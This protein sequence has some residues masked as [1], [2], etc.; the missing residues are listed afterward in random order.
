MNEKGQ[1]GNEKGTEDNRKEDGNGENGGGGEDKDGGEA[2]RMRKRMRVEKVK[3]SIRR[4]T[5]I[6]KLKI[7]SVK[8]K[9][10]EMRIMLKVFDAARHARPIE[11]VAYPFI[12][13]TKTPD[14]RWGSMQRRKECDSERVGWGKSQMR[15][16]YGKQEFFNRFSL[17]AWESAEEKGDLH[18]TRPTCVVIN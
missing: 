9:R 18:R 11:R 8:T 16:G 2:G 3:M 1:D 14:M 12:V 4:K 17:L 7:G 13:R 5:E 6:T 10:A 15:E